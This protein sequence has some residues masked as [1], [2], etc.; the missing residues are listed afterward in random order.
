MKTPLIRYLV[1]SPAG[2]IPVDSSR[3][4]FP[5]EGDPLKTSYRVYFRAITGFISGNNFR[6]LL[7]AVNARLGV[8]A[9][10]RALNE[11]I[12][13]T[14]KHGALCHP[15]S[16]ECILRDGRVKFGLHVAVTGTG[17]ESLR[18]EFDLLKTFH[19]RFGFREIP[20]PYY[21][22]EVCS[23]VF[24]LEEW[25][26]GY[27]EFHLSKTEDGGQ[28]LKLWEYGKGNRFLNHE[29]G[30]E[31][32]RQAARILTLCYDL[33][34]FR[35]IYP[36]HHAAGDF[37]A[38]IGEAGYSP[39]PQG[40]VEKIEG[41]R[42]GWRKSPASLLPLDE[43]KTCGGTPPSPIGGEGRG[44]G[45]VRNKIDVKLTTVR[46]YEPFMGLGED[47]MVSSAL[48]LFYFLLHLS[49]QM[50]LDR[51]DGVGESAWA[52]DYCVDATVT[53][54]FEGLERKKNFIECCGSIQSFLNLLQS[55]TKDELRKT[56]VPIAEQF[57]QTKD[58]RLIQ[59]HFGAHA[60]RLY[61]TLQNFPL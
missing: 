29:Q 32:Y 7:K 3:L 56:C 16:I 59:E 46:G 12:V 42:K 11:I 58:Y 61:L 36:W 6:P 9:D 45:H 30:F 34:D 18:K 33:R 35:M 23:M 31:I 60:G 55:F 28:A 40:R 5:L 54:F 14:E 10:L 8:G 4:D 51:L 22:D 53:G 52:A 20:T 38:R 44:D 15:A 19:S 50:R 2:D 39:S 27:H 17:K 25:F 13:R 43:G 26:E 37:V 48:A 49:V 1:A 47:K 57:E 41:I 21:L 24:L